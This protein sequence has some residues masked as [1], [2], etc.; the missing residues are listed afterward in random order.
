M[1]KLISG[2]QIAILLVAL[3]FIPVKSFSQDT[4][5]KNEKKEAKEMQENIRYQAIGALLEARK[6]EFQTEVVQPSTGA[7]VYNVV[8]I[9]GKRLYVRCE[10]P[11]NTSGSFSGARDNTT[12][13]ISPSTG[14]FFEG[15]IE[16][17]ELT[18]KTKNQY[19]TIKFNA[20]ARDGRQWGEIMMKAY[21]DESAHIEI[22]SYNGNIFYTSYTGKIQAF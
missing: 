8:Q 10:N 7:K 18:R 14:I 9:D 19:Y 21:A 20:I 16:N 15:D 22:R 2:I 3:I 12:P 4:G 6:I 1:K 13:N 5:S 11:Q 17:W